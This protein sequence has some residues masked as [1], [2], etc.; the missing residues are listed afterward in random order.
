MAESLIKGVS[1]TAFM[2]AAWRAAESERPD[3]LFRDPFAARLAG[4]HGQS[5]VAGVRGFLG[6][7]QVVI[8][9]L[10]ID[11]LIENAVAAGADTI[12]NLGAGL[13]ARPY[14]MELPESLHWIEVDYAQVI[15]WKA[16][17]LA[18]DRPRCRLDRIKLDLADLTARRALFAEI[19][20]SSE[21]I[22]ILT[23]GVLPYLTTDAVAVLADD[24]RTIFSGD[25]EISWIADYFSPE[26]IRYRKLIG[27]SRQ[28]RAAPLQFEPSD[29]LAFFAQH[30]WKLAEMRYLADEA[31]RRR[32]RMPLP[33]IVRAVVKIR[34][35]LSRGRDDGLRRYA[36]Y[37]LLKPTPAPDTRARSRRA[38]AAP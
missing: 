11:D 15:D 24:L 33:F 7:W 2:V 20:A 22:L 5:I 17:T 35:L 12:V 3:A 21:R 4:Q 19:A 31:V 10:I 6:G 9:T 37:A 23:E 18:G 16:D 34:R 29:W 13:D 32:R 26:T 27:L 30:G 8:R 38:N 25:V 14:R 28:M 1:D 36:G